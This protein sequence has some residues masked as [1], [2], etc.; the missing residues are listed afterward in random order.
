MDNKAIEELAIGLYE[1]KKTLNAAKTEEETKIAAGAFQEYAKALNILIEGNEEAKLLVKNILLK[2]EQEDGTL[3]TAI[4]EPTMHW[5]VIGAY[6][7]VN[8]PFPVQCGLSNKQIKSVFTIENCQNVFDAAEKIIALSKE[9][10]IVISSNFTLLYPIFMNLMG[11]EHEST[12]HMIAGIVLDESK[13]RNWKFDRIGGYTGKTESDFYKENEI[14]L[15]SDSNI[16]QQKEPSGHRVTSEI[17]KLAIGM[18]FNRNEYTQLS[19]SERLNTSYTLTVVEIIN[20]LQIKMTLNIEKEV[21]TD[22]HYE[23]SSED[24]EGIIV[25]SNEHNTVKIEL[26]KPYKNDLFL[27]IVNFT[28]K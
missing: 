13:I 5:A 11:T 1:R 6:P 8:P 10:S 2:L 26:T 27:N 25:A 23:Y 21:P 19:Q 20:D 4:N 28:Y 24:W 9:K 16:I 17:P 14:T 22:K 18:K 12:M 15:T 3:S 7:K